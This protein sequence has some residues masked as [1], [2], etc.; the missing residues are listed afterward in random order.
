M[1]P[2][3]ILAAALG[4]NPTPVG[5]GMD[6]TLVGSLAGLAAALVGLVIWFLRDRRKSKA[7][8]EVAEAT[9][10]AS[11]EK[12]D[13]DA[14]DARLVYVLRQVDAERAFHSQQVADRDAEIAR[15]RSE[16]DRRDELVAHLR[17]QIES[18]EERLTE[19]VEQ[20]SHVREQL[21][22]LANTPPG[23]GDH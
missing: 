6:A 15:Q 2:V 22:Q 9:I 19:A 18:L 10:R 3:L 14:H 13:F 23:M 5:G 21:N 11:V 16:L 20:M 17:A 1:P 12:R 8:T 7:E 4:V